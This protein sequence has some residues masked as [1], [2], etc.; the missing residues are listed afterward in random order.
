MEYRIPKGKAGELLLKA[1]SLSKDVKVDELDCAK[2][3]RRQPTD[4]TIEEVLKIGLEDG[5][6]FHF[7]YRLECGGYFDVGLRTC[8]DID[9]FLWIKLNYEQGRK[10]VVDF[11]LDMI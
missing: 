8:G 5:A 3:F 7:I 4:K 2:S 9:Y 10:L 1:I 6:S 11:E